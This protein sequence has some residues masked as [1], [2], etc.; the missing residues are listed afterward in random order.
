M[1]AL[2]CALEGH[3]LV[4][5]HLASALQGNPFMQNGTTPMTTNETVTEI[6][7]AARRRK[8]L[9]T[10]VN[11]INAKTVALVRDSLGFFTDL[12]EAERKKLKERAMAIF[13]TVRDGKE[14]ADADQAAANATRTIIL[15]SVAGTVEMVKERE[16]T[17][18]L[19][20]KLAADLPINDFIGTVRG[21]SPKGCAVLLGEAGE[22]FGDYR[23]VSGLWKRL[24]LSV[25][26]GIAAS[27]ARYYQPKAF[28]KDDWID[29]GYRPKA[30]AEVHAFVCDTMLRQQVRKDKETGVTNA[31]GPY[32][33]V[34]LRER[35]KKAAVVAATADLD[36]KDPAKWSPKRVDT[37]ARR[38]MAKA[39]IRD[40]WRVSRGMPPR[41]SAV[42]EIAVQ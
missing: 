23:T 40:L 27:T 25:H 15:G 38:V 3:P 21:F 13:A 28:T 20:S 37:H 4:V 11:G 14:V 41:G 22:Y 31:I 2:A 7:L 33:E 18:K 42:E 19:M 39:L 1:K 36:F 12:D 16:A 34:Y 32:G 8:N 6:V 5:N 17:E 35:A 9:I 29:V 30:R 26:K 24:G 10:A